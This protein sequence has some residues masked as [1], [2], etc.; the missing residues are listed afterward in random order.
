MGSIPICRA[1]LFLLYRE[2][3][4][5]IITVII[6]IHIHF[7]NDEELREIFGGEIKQP[8]RKQLTVIPPKTSIRDTTLD[9]YKVD[10]DVV[11]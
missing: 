8:K 7:A 5:S 10:V 6:D 1:N 9:R 2:V 11:E 4:I 3:I